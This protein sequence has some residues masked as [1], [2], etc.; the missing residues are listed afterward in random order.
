MLKFKYENGYI[1][2]IIENILLCM[3]DLKYIKYL[4]F[5]EMVINGKEVGIMVE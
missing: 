5:L 2:I 3:K 1:I 4:I